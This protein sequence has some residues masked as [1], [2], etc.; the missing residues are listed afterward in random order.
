MRVFLAGATGV[1]GRTLVPILLEAG[2]EVVG[3]SRSPE[4]AEAVRAT[5]AGCVVCDALDAASL[6]GAVKDARPEVVVNQLTNLPR[7]FNPRNPDY[8]LTAR[9][10]REA[11]ATL[12]GAAA[13]AGARR[14][15]SQSI[16]FI[17]APTGDPVK[18]E[19]A[20]LMRPSGSKF[21]EALEATLD[22][23][24]TTLDARGLEGLV[25]RYGWFYGPGTYYA[26]DGSSA[27]DVRRRRFPVVGKGSGVTS[28]IHVEDAALAT[29][30]ALD[31]GRPGVYNVTDDEPAAM[32]DWLPV[33]AQ[34][35]GAKPPRRV[36]A[37]LARLIAG[38][39]VVGQATQLRGASNA[40]AKR[41][42]GW[43]PRYP[44][45]RTGFFE[46]PR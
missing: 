31:H 34:S 39:F 37:W 42:L 21:D 17:Y 2:H 15:V 19:E 32:R 8:G 33:Y 35:L 46:A 27:E 44:S 36:P 24:R 29:L 12:A 9:L 20:P 3:T 45:W 14:L 28:F 10:R 7:R 40:K 43:R 1:I 26:Q 18:D 13:A 22:L 38:G 4:K 25:L 16:A 6:A 41:E 11:T 5:G 30:A 23:E